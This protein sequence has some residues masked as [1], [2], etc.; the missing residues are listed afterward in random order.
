MREVG[1]MSE[2]SNGL[3][4]LVDGASKSITEGVLLQELDLD[5]QN[6]IYH[7]YPNSTK[8]DFIC[9][10]HLLKYRLAK[11]DKMIVLKHRES[12][13]VNNRLTHIL[14]DKNFKI[15]N[16]NKHQKESYTFGQK[17]ADKVAHFGGSWRFIIISIC[18]MVVWIT[19][20]VFHLFNMH[21]DS[22]PFILLN[23]FLSMVAALQAP[24]I[25]MS[26]NRSSDYDRL[27]ADN[28]FHINLKTEEEMRVLHAKIDRII[29]KDNPDLFEV[30]KLQTKMLG[31]LQQQ[32]SAL[33][34]KNK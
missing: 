27:H 2:F 8:N 11:I 23:L 24:L 32:M 18:A 29:Q 21:F 5:L 28:D 6:A 10:D 19:I 13:H 30:Q 25:L 15:V 31:E 3:S 4:C 12:M 7:D 20:N 22:Y 34:R 33:E 9:L 1:M 16:V 26:Q 14:T 17:V